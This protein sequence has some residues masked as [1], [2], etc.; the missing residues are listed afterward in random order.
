MVNGNV[1]PSKTDETIMDKEEMV[2]LLN[3]YYASV[4]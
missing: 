3:K 4:V 1:G 2:C